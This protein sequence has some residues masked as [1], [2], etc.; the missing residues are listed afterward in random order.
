MTNWINSPWLRRQVDL[1]LMN[2]TLWL[3]KGYRLNQKQQAQLQEIIEL[4]KEKPDGQ[5]DQD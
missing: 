5:E 4:V 2:L 1:C 3:A